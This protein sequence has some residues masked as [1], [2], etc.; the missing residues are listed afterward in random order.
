MVL[1]LVLS[2]VAL[3]LRDTIPRALLV[4]AEPRQAA[5]NYPAAAAT[6]AAPLALLGVGVGG[7]SQRRAATPTAGWLTRKATSARASVTGGGGSA[8]A[9]I[10]GAAGPACAG[11][12]QRVRDHAVRT[13]RVDAHGSRPAARA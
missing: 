4:Q 1:L 11:T 5:A 8:A 3:P 10:V 9:V 12:S 7:S 2:A 6:S 13:C